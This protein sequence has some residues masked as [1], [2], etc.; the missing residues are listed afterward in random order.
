M[1]LTPRRCIIV[2]MERRKDIHYRGKHNASRAASDG[3][4]AH[5]V[6]ELC[7]LVADGTLTDKRAARVLGVNPLTMRE[8]VR[9]RERRAA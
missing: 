6:R 5:A 1:T 8:L 4:W 9:E 2:G 3:R 7:L